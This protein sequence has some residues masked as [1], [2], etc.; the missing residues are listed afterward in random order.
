[1]V[2]CVHSSDQEESHGTIFVV[3]LE[4]Y[5]SSTAL[6][7]TPAPTLATLLGRIPGLPGSP[8]VRPSV[9]DLIPLFLFGALPQMVCKDSHTDIA[10]K[11]P[12]DKFRGLDQCSPFELLDWLPGPRVSCLRIPTS[13]IPLVFQPEVHWTSLSA[14][15]PPTAKIGRLHTF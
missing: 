10:T 9:L 8:L 11:G 5:C 13:S 3:V 7:H 15:L 6:R 1:M 12:I 2:G 14:N 4:F